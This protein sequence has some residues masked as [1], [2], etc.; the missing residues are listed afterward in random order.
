MRTHLTAATL[1]TA[2]SIAGAV[3]PPGQA[4]Q[5][6]ATVTDSLF[7]P[8][9]VA[10]GDFNGDGLTDLADHLAVLAAFGNTGGPAYAG[11]DVTGDGGDLL[12]DLLAVLA[13][14]G[15]DCP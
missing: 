7:S 3:C 13:A 15:T 11:G 6:G 9:R 2:A 10:P 4:L 5:P 14:F 8:D 1:A 12:D